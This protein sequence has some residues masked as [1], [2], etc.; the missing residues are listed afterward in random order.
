MSAY[1]KF[2]LDAV[3]PAKVA[4]AAKR[5]PALASL[6]TLAVPPL[7]AEGIPIGA[8]PACGAREFWRWP[9]QHAQHDGKWRCYRCEPI[10][11]NAGP[12]DAVAVP[13]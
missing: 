6:A 4:K 8:C 5:E 10:P 12:C 9:V 7:D 11:P 13:A 3:T 1:R 2:D